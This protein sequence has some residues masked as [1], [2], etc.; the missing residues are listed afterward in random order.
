[1]K[2]RYGVIPSGRLMTFVLLI[3]LFSLFGPPSLFG[4]EDFWEGRV[5]AAAYGDL[6]ARGRYA[7]SNAF[8][9]DSK[10][11]ISHPENGKEIE[12]RVV[13]RLENQRVLM[14]VSPEVADEL[15]ISRN[16]VLQ[17]R[18]RPLSR[19][20]DPVSRDFVEE[21]AETADPD[22]NPGAGDGSA[23]SLIAEYLALTEIG[24][25]ETTEE[26][27]EE[28]RAAEDDHEP[29]DIVETAEAEEPETSEETTEEEP[30]EAEAAE[31]EDRLL[32]VED[33][34]ELS[35][36]QRELPTMEHS[37]PRLFQSE[38]KA[39]S[40]ARDEEATAA[41]DEEEAEGDAPPRIADLEPVFTQ[42][43]DLSYSRLAPSP[44]KPRAKEEGPEE[45]LPESYPE[46]REIEE[47]RLSHHPRLPEEETPAADMVATETEEETEE[48]ELAHEPDLKTGDEEESRDLE[49][50]VVEQEEAEETEGESKI[51]LVPAEE[52]PPE[53]PPTVEQDQ[54]METEELE[55]V[56][57]DDTSSPRVAA[58]EIPVR[59]RLDRQS[60]YLQVAAYRRLELAQARASELAERYP[61]TIYSSSEG[62]TAPFKLMVGP[63]NEDESGTLLFT[64]NS[65]GY[66]DAFVRRGN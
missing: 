22:L 46:P 56:P 16:D 28:T 50:E 48:P 17:V 40:L 34:P 5:T 51:V 41:P 37:S 19:Q 38:P 13:A 66:K 12:V 20:E 10:V 61:V 57:S 55:T 43:K 31:G 35:P 23:E 6:P 1:M 11:V 3:F 8:P 59:N 33:M 42:E 18:I 7:A 62:E 26:I 64:F 44:P 30:E 65:Q 14:E 9:L 39:E 45:S 15:N 2:N 63:L 24:E 60:Y 29:E 25:D 52:R 27:P 49:A 54:E 4:Q 36:E 21:R 58:E 53:G 47:L 32:A